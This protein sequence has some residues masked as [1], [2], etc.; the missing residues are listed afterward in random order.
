VAEVALKIAVYT[1]ALDEAAHVDRWADSAVDADHR[2]VGDTG[3]SDDTV[4][5]LLNKGVTVHRIG[6]KLWRFDDA[7]NAVMSL[8]LGDVDVC[9]TMDMDVYLAPG[10]R[11]AGARRSRPPG[12]RGPRP[13]ISG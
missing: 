3:S 5:R 1:I 9:L 8:I 7:R 6:I 10:W 2:I 13:S 12:P 11:L 4:E